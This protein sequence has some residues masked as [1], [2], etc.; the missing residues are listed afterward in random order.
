MRALAPLLLVSVLALP[1]LARA[2]ATCDAAGALARA[3]QAYPP[4]GPRSLELSST[5]TLHE[6]ERVEKKK[7]VE[8]YRFPE[9]ARFEYHGPVSVLVLGD[10]GKTAWRLTTHGPV[11]SAR[12]HFELPRR[13][14]SF[15]WVFG[16]VADGSAECVA[17]APPGQ[18]RLL[19][20]HGIEEMILVDI[21]GRGLVTRYQGESRATGAA[22]LL[23]VDLSDWRKVGGHWVAHR[24]V[25][26][27]N[28]KPYAEALVDAARADID[29]PPAL[30]QA[31]TEVGVPA[32]DL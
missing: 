1:V 23:Q 29:I 6:G 26:T 28:G 30:F 13:I 17:G 3:R 9:G 14:R 18:T 12:A 16:A 24:V 22:D 4:P 32:R 31:P 2:D 7:F 10:T 11:P 15:A 20:T 27:L 8:R 21:D 25:T 5:L 19:L